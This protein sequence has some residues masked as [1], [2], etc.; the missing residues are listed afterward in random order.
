MWFIVYSLEPAMLNYK[1]SVTCMY[2]V[3]KEFKETQALIWTGL[4]SI[5]VFHPLEINPV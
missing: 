5:H 1:I 4:L 3:H 2:K